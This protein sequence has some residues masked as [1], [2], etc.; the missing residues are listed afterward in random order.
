M[1][2]Y[3]VPTQEFFARCRRNCTPEMHSRCFQN[4]GTFHLTLHEQEM[5]EDDAL[6]VQFSDS[7][8]FSDSTDP[9]LLAPFEVALSSG[10]LI[11]AQGSDGPHQ[12]NEGWCGAWLPWKACLALQPAP[13]AQA[14]IADLCN[15]DGLTNLPPAAGG[16]VSASGLKRLHMSLYRLRGFDRQAML[17]QLD[18]IRSATCDVDQRRAVPTD[19]RVSAGSARAVAVCMKVVGGAYADCRVLARFE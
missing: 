5:S 3:G 6:A 10:Q 12:K 11:T 17:A 18:Q 15:R 19:L 13:A 7:L 14:Q 4:D 8:Q 1:A 2:G 9:A 16:R